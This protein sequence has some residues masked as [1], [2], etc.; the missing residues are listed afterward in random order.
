MKPRTVPLAVRRRDSVAEGAG[1]A[2][3][4]GH[5]SFKSRFAEMDR[6][7]IGRLFVP[8]CRWTP[9]GDFQIETRVLVGGLGFVDSAV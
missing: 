4:L 9:C 2:V 3:E 8:G 1:H 6:L 5:G 7:A